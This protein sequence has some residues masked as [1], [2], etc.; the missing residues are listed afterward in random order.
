MRDRLTFMDEYFQCLRVLWV[1]CLCTCDSSAS[2][3]CVGNH[4]RL[5]FM[6]QRVGRH[7]LLPLAGTAP[8]AKR[9]GVSFITSPRFSLIWKNTPLAIN[10]LDAPASCKW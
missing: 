2:S 1:P 8:S 3:A 7:A 5:V 6:A 10:H 9:G 4:R